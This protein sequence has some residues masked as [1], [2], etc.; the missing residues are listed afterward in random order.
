M[1]YSEL[2]SSLQKLSDQSLR[3]SRQLD[4]TYYSILEKVSVLR[5]TIGS[6]QELS[7][8]T[9][10]LHHQF[11]ADTNE[12]VDEVQG[13]LE[14]FSNFNAQEEQVGVLEERIKAGKDRAEYLTK[15]LDDARKRVEVRAKVEAEWEA[16]TTRMLA[17]SF[18]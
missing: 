10:E 4:D 2:R 14:G 17:F 5:Q 12:L 1:E 13:Q 3:T 16:R 9:K 11:E 8:R 7:G 15:R 18:T 6:L